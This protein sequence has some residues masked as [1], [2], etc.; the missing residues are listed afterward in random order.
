MRKKAVR[1][2]TGSYGCLCALLLVAGCAGLPSIRVPQK[3]YDAAIPIPDARLPDYEKLTYEIRWLGLRVG[4]LTASI[5]ERKQFRDREVY[6]L[7][8]TVKTSAFFS[9]IY[10]IEDRFVSYVDAQK[11]YT[12][13]H[14]VYRRDG[15]YK[16]D[17]VTEFDQESHKAHF[18]NSLDMSEKTFDIPAG[19]HDILSACYYFML[20][21]LKVGDKIE[22]SVCN[23]ETNYQFLGL[24]QPKVLIRVPAL[25]RKE[26]EAFLIQPY[27]KL[28]GEKVDKGNVS[29]YFSCEKRRLPLLATVK[30]PV[31]TE[32]TIVLSKIENRQ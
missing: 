5:V 2:I 32:V 26:S 19:V 15:A 6:V 21:P 12:I 3:A 24:I 18:K 4:T 25:G 28:K 30:G 10:K 23:N 14:E 27:A 22:Y 29:A 13:R 9:S 7:E 17:A 16:K 1:I 31:F 20:L 8:A 11:L